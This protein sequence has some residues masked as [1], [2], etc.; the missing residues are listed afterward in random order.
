MRLVFKKYLY[1][2]FRVAARA[3]WFV[4]MRLKRS[5]IKKILLYPVVISDDE[6][7]DLANRIAWWLPYQSNIKITIPVSDSLID[8]NLNDLKA[9]HSQRNYLDGNLDHIELKINPAITGYDI[10]LLN[11]S[12]RKKDCLNLIRSRRIA[13]I[14]KNT[15]STADTLSWE[16]TYRRAYLDD[17]LAYFEKLSRNNYENMLDQFQGRNISYC[18]ASG[19]SFSCYKDF[20]I[21]DN[22]ISIVCN[23]TIRDRVFLEHIGGPDIVC[24]MDR[25]GFFTSS[26]YSSVF[27]DKLIDVYKKY[28]SFIITKL[29][30]LPLLLSHFPLLEDRIIG[31][32]VKML[33]D[34]HF[35]G[36]Q[37]LIT[38]E[39]NN[40]L[41][42]IMIPVASALTDKINIL[43]ADG[44]KPGNSK[45]NVH[46]WDHC[47]STGHYSQQ[48]LH[49]DTHPLDGNNK[50]FKDIYDKHCKF[51]EK[52]LLYGELKEKHYRSLTPSHVPALQ[53]RYYKR[54]A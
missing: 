12:S 22:S 5:N 38:A 11:D 24:F 25:R 36:P 9:P 23:N 16:S 14:D 30:R 53:K 54:L 26:V 39:G 29:E 41:T 32:K 50:D 34:F 7:A 20:I 44:R 42:S 43:G 15:C 46:T 3:Y 28:H 8:I 17:D 40:I 10:M 47:E 51:I 49:I 6:L 19:P 2:I 33:Q 48:H 27:R 31:I 18:F 37:S 52:L 35:P 21:E 1:A 13:V 45:N 4:I